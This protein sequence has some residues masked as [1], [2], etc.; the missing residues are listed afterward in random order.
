[1]KKPKACQSQVDVILEYMVAGGKLT[2]LK[3]LGMFG[4]LALSQRMTNIR[5]RIEERNLP[6]RVV[7]EMIKTDTGKWIAEYGLEKK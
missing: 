2:A 3:A 1:M 6:Y 4:V 5:N 7:R